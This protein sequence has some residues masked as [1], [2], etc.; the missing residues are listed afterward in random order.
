MGLHQLSGHHSAG[1]LRVCIY[2]GIP[3]EGLDLLITF[4]EQFRAKYDIR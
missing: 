2:N 3:D 4:M 1:G